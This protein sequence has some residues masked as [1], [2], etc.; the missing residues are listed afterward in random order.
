MS[1][2]MAMYETSPVLGSPSRDPGPKPEPQPDDPYYGR[3]NAVLD[4]TEAI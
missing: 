3:K 4:D 1:F 2:S